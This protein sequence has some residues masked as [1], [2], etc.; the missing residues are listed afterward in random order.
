M[1]KMSCFIEFGFI[2]VIFISL[3]LLQKNRYMF[4][5]KYKLIPWEIQRKLISGLLW[6]REFKGNL[7][8]INL[9]LPCLSA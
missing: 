9:F 4:Y 6:Y 1:N 3:G 2:F 8:T 5:Q 7:K